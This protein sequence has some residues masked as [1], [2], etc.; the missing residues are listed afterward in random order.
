MCKQD[1]EILEVHSTPGGKV[2]SQGVLVFQAKSIALTEMRGYSIAE[3]PLPVVVV[4]RKDAYAGRAFTLIHEFAHLMLRASGVC[5]LELGPNRTTREQRTEIFC[6]HVAGAVLVPKSRFLAE[7]S[8]RRHKGYSW[9]DEELELVARNFSVSREVILRRALILGLTDEEFYSLKR[10][11]LLR[12]YEV[13]TKGEG[14]IP[15]HTD[16]LSLSGKPFVKLVLNS[17]YSD[18]ITAS[19]VSE[20]LGFK[21]QHLEKINH[22]V[23]L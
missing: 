16:V 4:N 17:Y 7:Q 20:Y 14:F 15:P 5:N 11:Q 8:V 10:E 22:A 19:D 23:G 18:K 3:S 12:E 1:G 2:E 21:L 13:R 6:N 9:K